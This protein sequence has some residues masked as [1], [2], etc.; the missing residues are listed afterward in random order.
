MLVNTNINM[1]SFYVDIESMATFVKEQAISDLSMAQA[2]Q[3]LYLCSWDVDQAIAYS[4]KD[5]TPSES[6]SPLKRCS[7]CFSQHNQHDLFQLGCGHFVHTECGKRK[8]MDDYVLR[9]TC[10]A[11]NCRHILTISE[12]TAISGSDK[13]YKKALL[14][15]FMKLE[16]SLHPQ[17]LLRQKRFFRK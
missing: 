1:D 9:S 15:D 7:L 6:T 16:M 3:I 5:A 13:L 17:H 14:E 11:R 4:Q 8:L 12:I 10:G 2:I